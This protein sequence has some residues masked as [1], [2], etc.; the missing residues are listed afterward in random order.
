MSNMSYVRFENTAKDFRDCLY[1]MTEAEDLASMDLSSSEGEAMD[2]MYDHC[3]TF[4]ANYKRLK[5]VSS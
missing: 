1:A 4:L 3:L 5:E 2:E